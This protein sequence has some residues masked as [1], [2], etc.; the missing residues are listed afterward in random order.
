MR[1]P[2]LG[3]S[4]RRRARTYE[5]G[6]Q[7]SGQATCT[8]AANGVGC[9]VQ[10]LVDG[11]PTGTGSVNF[12]TSTSASPQAKEAVQTTV[13]SAVVGPGKHVITARYAGAKDTSVGFKVFDWNLIAE[14]YPGV[15]VVEEETE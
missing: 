5:R 10:L 7:F 1:S 13:Q 9:P 4:S 2:A 14:A 15:E 3:R 6:D 11:S 8:A 12:L